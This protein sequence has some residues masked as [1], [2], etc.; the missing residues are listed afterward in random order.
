MELV[1]SLYKLCKLEG[2]PQDIRYSI[3]SLVIVMGITLAANVGILYTVE[4][5]LAQANVTA[6]LA[7]HKQMF[8]ES[9]AGTW[10]KIRYSLIDV[11]TKGFCLYLLLVFRGVSVRFVQTATAIFGVTVL[12]FFLMSMLM[13]FSYLISNA[14]VFAELLFLITM[15]WSF[16]VNIRIFSCALSIEYWIASFV[17]LVFGVGTQA[18]SDLVLG[19]VLKV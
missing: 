19:W 3:T 12:I 16:I 14:I 1:R 15:I 17:T 11:G 4:A 6:E 10:N 7:Q 13:V 18:L 8:L 2:K 5:K 9:L